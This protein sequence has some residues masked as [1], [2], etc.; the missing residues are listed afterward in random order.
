MH[1]VTQRA[2][3]ILQGVPADIPNDATTLRALMLATVSAFYEAGLSRAEVLRLAGG[4][5]DVIH[6][7]LQTDRS[8]HA[9]VPCRAC[10][11]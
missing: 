11:H 10:A 7:A 1:A 3:A 2:V 6:E 4:D 8:A 5:W 9:G